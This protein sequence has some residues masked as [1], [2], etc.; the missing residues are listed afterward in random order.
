MVCPDKYE[1]NFN[2]VVTFLTQYIEEREPSPSLKVALI[3]QTRPAEQH[4]TSIVHCTFR[5]KVES[6]KCSKEEYDSMST[7]QQQ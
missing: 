7:A 3:A 5:K 2:A 1:K 6:K 4:K